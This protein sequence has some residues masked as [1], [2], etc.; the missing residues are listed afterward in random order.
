MGL[1]KIR[2][3]KACGRKFTPKSQQPVQA[4]I[5]D[6][7]QPEAVEPISI[8]SPK[9]IP[10]E[11][12]EPIEPGTPRPVGPE[13][14]RPVEPEYSTEADVLPPSSRWYDTP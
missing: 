11:N 3:C 5:P 1:R 10:A 7:T 14:P 8:E 12:P 9:A 2:R 13:S 6:T 4:E